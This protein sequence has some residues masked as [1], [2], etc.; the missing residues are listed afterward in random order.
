ML[1]V[2]F[3]IYA[4]G[5][6]SQTDVCHKKLKFV[7]QLLVP[8]LS[9]L[10]I[11]QVG[12]AIAIPWSSSSVNLKPDAPQGAA[13]YD[14]RVRTLNSWGK[15]GHNIQA[16]YSSEFGLWLNSWHNIGLCHIMNLV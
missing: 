6:T 7:L 9:C 11:S 14:H 15:Y 10:S 16:W 4:G 13:L 12:T 3:V 5:I 2:N 8:Y 1:Q